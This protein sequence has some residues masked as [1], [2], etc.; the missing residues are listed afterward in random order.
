MANRRQ[1]LKHVGVGGTVLVAGCGGGGSDVGG[2]DGNELVYVERDAPS[3]VDP[4][5][6]DTTAS[7]SLLAYPENAYETL[8][9]FAPDDAGTLEPALASEVPDRD[10]GLISD[11]G[12][13]IEF[14]LREGVQFH[15]GGEMT[16]EDVKFS[17]ERTMEMGV[18]PEASRLDVVESTEVVDDYTFRVTLSDPFAPFMTTVVTR[19]IATVVSKEAVEENGGVQ[20]GQT[21]QWV[22]QNTAG[23]GPYNLGRYEP[24]EQIT[25]EPHEDYWGETNVDRVV[26]MARSDLSGQISMISNGDAHSGRIPADNFSEVEGTP[27]TK[28]TFEPAFDPAHLTLNFDIPYDRDNMDFDDTVPRDFFQDPNVRKG[29]AYAFD[30]ETYIEEVWSGH[31]SRFNQYH[32]PGMVGYDES[33]PN[34][35]HD[36]EQ[37]EEHFREAGYWEEGFQVTCFNENIAQFERGNLLLKDNIE[38]LND[39]FTLN[40]QSVPET[41]MIPR[42]SADKFEFPMEFHG[43]LPQGADPDPYY[44]SVYSPEGSVGSRSAVEEILDGEM[45]LINQA[46]AT[47]DIDEREEIYAE[48]Q[49]KCFDNPAVIGIS[50]EEL[51][52]TTHECVEPVI[53]PAWI[54]PHFKHW[55]VSNCDF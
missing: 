2:G 3:T 42:H 18:S 36:P 54:Q 19:P 5:A 38:A 16:A 21:N 43:F 47:P 23:T 7:A 46:A 53:N 10:N 17:W 51:L 33:A 52:Q 32:F 31:A 25:W 37:A 48:L 39:N 40:I 4:H 1:F 41:Q 8:V 50:V 11:D 24:D 28:F 26:Q 12:T 29:F 30:Y 13:T 27:N 15:T 45:E 14:P 55:D 44:R 6:V 9:Y 49:R 20:E 35:E 22:A 34:F